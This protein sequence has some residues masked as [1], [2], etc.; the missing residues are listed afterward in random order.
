MKEDINLFTPEI[1]YLWSEAKIELNALQ[2][3]ISRRQNKR[4]T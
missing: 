4:I 2:K 1:F 3:P